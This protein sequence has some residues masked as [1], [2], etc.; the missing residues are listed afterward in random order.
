MH[1][2]SAYTFVYVAHH[3]PS[4]THSRCQRLV[5][6]Y[7]SCAI[8][9]TQQMH[10]SVSTYDS[11]SSVLSASSQHR[12]LSALMSPRLSAQGVAGH[13]HLRC[14]LTT[15]PT[16]HCPCLALPCPAASSPHTVFNVSLMPMLGRWTWSWPTNWCWCHIYQTGHRHR[17]RQQHA[18]VWW[19]MM[20]VLVRAGRGGAGRAALA[21]HA[22]KQACLFQPGPDNR[23]FGV[24]G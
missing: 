3:V 14:C 8:S 6:C 7:T 11:S 18:A 10:T 20:A 16:L 22:S 23:N 12:R 9:H 21:F 13:H 24:C 4:A 15:T 2:M 5:I 1:R 19:C 17:R